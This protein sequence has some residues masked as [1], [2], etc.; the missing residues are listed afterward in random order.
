MSNLAEL[1]GSA[2]LWVFTLSRELSPEDRESIEHRLRKFVSEWTAHGARVGGAFEI[3]YD[4]FILVAADEEV[5]AVSGCSI[6]SLFRSVRASLSEIGVSTSDLAMIAYRHGDRVCE[7]SRAEF[8]ELAARGEVG[9]DTTVF[10]HTI[11][12]VDSLRRGKWET[13][14]A[15]SWHNAY[16][17]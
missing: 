17:C 5:A 11:N 1:P 15:D 14:A 3:R 7:V 2:R 8:K 6:D 9:P 16:L 13:R 4:K 12:T 10:D